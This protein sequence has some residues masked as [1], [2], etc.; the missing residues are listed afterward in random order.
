[1]I[2][3]LDGWLADFL[4][5]YVGDEYPVRTV[6]REYFECY[7]IP[8]MIEVPEQVCD[9]LRE[10]RDY[11]VRFEDSDGDIKLTFVAPEELI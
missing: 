4:R 5:D 1:M 7:R 6:S 11:Y 8:Y 2:C 10:H 9:Y 3:V